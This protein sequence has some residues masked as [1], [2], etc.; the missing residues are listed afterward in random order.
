MQYSGTAFMSGAF[1]LSHEDAIAGYL[2]AGC[3]P[4]YDLVALQGELQSIDTFSGRIARIAAGPNTMALVSDLGE[5]CISGAKS[6]HTACVGVERAPENWTGS[7]TIPKLL[8]RRVVHVACGAFHF[9][10]ITDA[11][12]LVLWGVNYDALD[13]RKKMQQQQRRSQPPPPPPPPGV[14][15]L[16]LP[17]AA[18]MEQAATRSLETSPSVSPRSTS[19]TTT[20]SASTATTSDSPT[21]T[22]EES[23]DNTLSDNE[24][25][26]E[27]FAA[28][29]GKSDDGNLV[30]GQLGNST[31]GCSTP[32]LV[33]V[34]GRLLGVSCGWAHT[35]ALTTDGV[36]TCGRST[37]GELGRE[38]SHTELLRVN[39]MPNVRYTIVQVACGWYHTMALSE[40]GVVFTW[41]SNSNGQLGVGLKSGQ[42]PLPQQLSLSSITYIS[43]GAAHSAAIKAG[44]DLYMWG[45]NRFGELGL[46]AGRGS[47]SEP[48]PVQV[49]Y[50]QQRVEVVSQVSCGA[51]ITGAVTAEG[52]AYT[53]GMLLA[54]HRRDHQHEP[55]RVQQLHERSHFVTGVTCG[56]T[57]AVFATDK[58]LTLAL[59]AM[60]AACSKGAPFNLTPLKDVLMS[61]EA[62]EH[63][64]KVLQ[65]RGL[66]MFRE[67]NAT[68]AGAL[69]Y[70]SVYQG[71]HIFQCT[72][73]GANTVHRSTIIEN[74][75]EH[76]II[77]TVSHDSSTPKDCSFSFPE[78]RFEL[79]P[80]GFSDLKCTFSCKS[81]PKN[82]VAALVKF[83]IER[84][85]LDVAELVR[86]AFGDDRPV[87]YYYVFCVAYPPGVEPVMQRHRS[88]KANR[89]AEADQAAAKTTQKLHEL[90]NAMA[91]YVPRVL[92]AQFQSSPRPPT[93]PCIQQFPASILFIDISG[94][95]SLNERLAAL[96]AAGPELVS[97][98]INAYFGSLI[99]AVNNHGGDVL[100]FA[101]DA[102][103]CMFSNNSSAAAASSASSSS[104]DA[105]S[106]LAS[107]GPPS[108]VSAQAHATDDDQQQSLA[109]LTLRA[110]QCG[111]EIQTKL[112]EYDS[113]EGFRLTLHIGIGSGPL[114][115]LYVG[116]TDSSWEY[117]VS[118]EP[119][120]Q[121]RTAVDNS[122][123]GEVVVSGEAWELIKDWCVG[124]PRGSDW[125]VRSISKSVAVKPSAPIFPSVEAEAALRAFIPQAVLARLDAKQIGWMDELRTVTVLFVKLNSEFDYK[126]MER[127]CDT[128]HKVLQCMQKVIF[129]YEGMVRQFLADDK[130]HISRVLSRVIFL[131]DY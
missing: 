71:F 83:T 88:S 84:K 16:Q 19:A 65:D 50:F 111:F 59:Q 67:S 96:G 114:Y 29:S 118:G 112:A 2:L 61:I 7:I 100:K 86:G 98:H 97:K 6:L 49:P 74:K 64:I 79:G 17:S 36:Y 48:S 28:P 116:G 92:L 117:L 12:E 51:H 85:K 43:A 30:T 70:I 39:L 110:V 107:C 52:D 72:S 75:S 128:I 129:Q 55:L 34:A 120:A 1:L 41:G 62:P 68:L 113:N 119:L 10:A 115:S 69:P 33:R 78:E 21:T 13:A 101:G 99:L 27:A 15:T 54:P 53:W 26:L 31:L 38:G 127:Y 11:D 94:F 23:S 109:L 106:S 47:I 102:L 93:E 46:G 8:G 122:H 126:R 44:G 24:D 81:A 77:I 89:L 124:E 3:P 103:I 56:A 35:A 91:T 95:T 66:S 105:S 14:T 73:P 32:L 90:V 108:L 18:E 82:E 121:L 131:A 25:E 57:H 123:T 130:V 37:C 9:A 5:L 125:Y 58:N 40:C 63:T 76:S 80:L 22:G 20:N 4:T 104:T 45:S 87:S 60:A 42:L